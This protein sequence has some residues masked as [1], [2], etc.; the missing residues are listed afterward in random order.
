MSGQYSHFMPP[1]KHQKPLV[2][3]FQGL[4]NEDIGLK[5]VRSI[6]ISICALFHNKLKDAWACLSKFK[7]Y[8]SQVFDRTWR[9]CFRKLYISW[10]AC[11]VSRSTRWTNNRWNLSDVSFN[12]YITVKLNAIGNFNKLASSVLECAKFRVFNPC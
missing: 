8:S 5:W 2:F 12:G 6:I 10:Y 11:L 3:C 7:N 9:T 4:K 1:E